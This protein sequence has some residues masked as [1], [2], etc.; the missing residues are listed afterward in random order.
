[1]LLDDLGE[2]GRA[3]GRWFLVALFLNSTTR[4]NQTGKNLAAEHRRNHPTGAAECRRK[5]LLGESRCLRRFSAEKLFC[6]A[7]REYF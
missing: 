3:A 1:L 2:L 7:L 6:A 5:N 4:R